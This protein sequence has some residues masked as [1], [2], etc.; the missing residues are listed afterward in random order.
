MQVYLRAR[1]S[2]ALG[3]GAA[4]VQYVTQRRGAVAAAAPQRMVVE[5]A[6]KADE[7]EDDDDLDGSLAGA[8]GRI[9]RTVPVVG[10]PLADSVALP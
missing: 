4:R 10:P 7:E 6:G 3:E 9:L 2:S 5:A 1:R 8:V